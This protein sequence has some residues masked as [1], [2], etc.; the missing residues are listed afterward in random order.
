MSR[1]PIQI[2]LGLVVLA[3]AG[4]PTPPIQ[5]RHP[6]VAAAYAEPE[7]AFFAA[8]RRGDMG[9][10][11]RL[12]EEKIIDVNRTDAYSWTGLM[13]AIQNGHA[14]LRNICFLK[15]PGSTPRTKT[16]SRRS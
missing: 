11:M 16:G 13:Y 15:R 6:E 7:T 3:L 14:G 2:I 4:C 10:V 5:Q 8:T 9:V 12:V 1:L